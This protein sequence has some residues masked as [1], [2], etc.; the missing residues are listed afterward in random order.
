ML[1]MLTDRGTPNILLSDERGEEERERIALLCKCVCHL[2]ISKSHNA[3]HK[4]VKLKEAYSQ[5]AR[6]GINGA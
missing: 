4:V 2:T 5:I 3:I 1:R 6:V